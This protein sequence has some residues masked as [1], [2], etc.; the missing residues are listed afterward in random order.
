MKQD[1]IH[2]DNVP[3]GLADALAEDTQAQSRWDALTPLGR[4]DFVSWI[5]EA[6]QPATRRKRI[7][8]ALSMLADGKARPCCF[9]VVPLDLHRGLK[10]N[11]AAQERWK[12]LDG[13]ER[14]DF[15]D[16]IRDG[17]TPAEV[18]ERS[19]EACAKIAAGEREPA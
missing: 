15:A 6:R 19:A 17:K 2:R 18:R 3:T 1:R 7:T 8:V 13:N 5:T 4:R 14:R 11:S 16:W 12:D 10:A 9:A